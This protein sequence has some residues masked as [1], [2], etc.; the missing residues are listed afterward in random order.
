[1]ALKYSKTKGSIKAKMIRMEHLIDLESSHVA[2]IIG[3]NGSGKSTL[4]NQLS[5]KYIAQ[6]RKV[7]AIANSIHD[8]FNSQSRNFSLLG[9]RSGRKISQR[10][11][12]KAL[13]NLDN[14]DLVKT[15]RIGQILEYVGYQNEI[16]FKVNVLKEVREY[17]IEEAEILTPSELQ[18]VSTLINKLNNNSSNEIHWVRLDEFRYDKMNSSTITRLLKHEKL[19]RKLNVISTVEVFLK[20]NWE[21]IDLSEASSGELSFITSLV[22]ISTMISE[23]SVILI[24]EPENSLHPRWQREYIAKLMDIFYLHQPT[25]VC[26]THSPIVVSGAEV[27]EQSL[28]IFKSQNNQL[29]KLP[30]NSNNLE[31]LLWEMFGIATPENRYLSNLITNTLNELAEN[32][33]DLAQAQRLFN[34]L[35]NEVYDPKQKDVL[36]SVRKLADKIEQRKV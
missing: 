34:L 1:L 23:D 30:Q 35:E 10:T 17:E 32:Q 29:E 13:L 11:V 3:E 8:K 31:Q 25:V 16:G 6:G 21:P 36:A 14:E 26:A 22:F 15:K 4:L 18:D 20:K 7:I 24:D 28:S 5:K 19:L 27:S 12:K 33:I 9:Y 2:V